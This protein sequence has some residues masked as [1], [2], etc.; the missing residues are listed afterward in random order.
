MTRSSS[1]TLLHLTV[2]FALFLSIAL[3][4]APAAAAEDAPFVGWSSALPA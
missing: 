2:G 4:A 3:V 1:S